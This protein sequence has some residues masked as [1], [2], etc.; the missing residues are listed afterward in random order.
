MRVLTKILYIYHSGKNQEKF[1]GL[2]Q[3][4]KVDREKELSLLSVIT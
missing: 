2:K 3:H 1:I 4:L